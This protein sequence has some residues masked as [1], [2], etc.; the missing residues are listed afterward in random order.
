MSSKQKKTI[1]GFIDREKPLTWVFAI[2]VA[3]LVV[4]LAV[5]LVLYY[6]MQ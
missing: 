6:G 4:P 3:M 1:L 2:I 5:T